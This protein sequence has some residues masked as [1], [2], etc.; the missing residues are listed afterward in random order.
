MRHDWCV[1]KVDQGARVPHVGAAARGRLAAA[2]DRAPIAAAYLFGSRASG[3]VGPLS[4]VDIGV[5]TVPDVSDEV[6][7]RRG[8]FAAVT[9]AL[10]TTEVDLVLLDDASP[11]L[12]HRV[13]RDGQ[14][15]IDRDPRLR[16]R[17]ETRALLD[18]LDTAPLREAQ[19]N[20]RRG[21]LTEGSFGRR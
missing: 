13:L 10:G 2:L 20:G 16:V 7:L 3:N 14:L 4:D 12:R 19:A 8:L 21:R 15:L 17:F 9:S 6:A 18:Y 5:V 11:L 1:T